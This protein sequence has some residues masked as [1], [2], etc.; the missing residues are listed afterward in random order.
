MDNIWI[1]QIGNV[2][3]VTHKNIPLIRGLLW[4]NISHFALHLT[5]QGSPLLIRV[6]LLSE[7]D[8]QALYSPFL[9]ADFVRKNPGR[10]FCQS[11]AL[12]R[13]A[14]VRALMTRLWRHRL[15]DRWL[16]DRTQVCDVTRKPENVNKSLVN[17]LE[18]ARTGAFGWLGGVT[19]PDGIWRLTGM[20]PNLI[21][22]IN[23]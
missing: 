20:S 3:M 11:T 9:A 2:I 16:I 7:T 13:H 8:L 14:P 12:W 18:G 6:I 22:S 1:W 23:R 4:A 17:Q 5:L 19:F 15:V 21:R 10:N